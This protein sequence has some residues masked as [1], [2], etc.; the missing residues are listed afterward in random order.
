MMESFWQDLRFGFRVL[1]K[2]RGFLVVSA[3]TLALAIGANTAL[4]SLVNGILLSPLPFQQ[5]ERLLSLTASL[6]QGAFVPFRDQ[7]KSFQAAA[8]NDVRSNLSGSEGAV[9]LT[10]TAVSADFFTVLEIGRAHV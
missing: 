8:Y 7:V 9:R 1:I 2:S 10:A 5:P 4:Y 3:L 6:Q